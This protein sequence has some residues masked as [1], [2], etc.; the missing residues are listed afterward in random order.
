MIRVVA[1]LGSLLVALSACA[2]GGARE[3]IALPNG[4]YLQPDQKRQTELV[5]RD[6]H[7]VLPGTIAAYSVSGQIVA[8]ALGSA[9]SAGHSYANDLPFHGGPDTR[10]FILDTRDGRLDKDLDATAWHQRLNELGE[11]GS[12]EIY[13]PLA[14]Q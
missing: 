8:G 7:R 3:V 13:P 11:P 12:L 4:Y 1:I 2:G 9:S 6:G 10:Y 14:W 5:K